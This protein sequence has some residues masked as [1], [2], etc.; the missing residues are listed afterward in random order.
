[1][2]NRDLSGMW[3]CAY[4]YPSN[5]HPGQREMTEYYVQ[6]KQRGDKVTFES[7]PN[8]P[9]HIVVNVTINES[10]ATGNWVENTDPNKEFA[11]MQ[12]SGALQML[13][14]DDDSAMIG[15]WVG[16]GRELLKNGSY[17]PRIYTGSWE[18]HR[19]GTDAQK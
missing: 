1:M 14:Q 19:L 6:A 9:D 13:I 12:Y 17:E 16:V 4:W 10:L 7:L 15:A 3:R 11:G 8:R 18:M 2:A 5:N